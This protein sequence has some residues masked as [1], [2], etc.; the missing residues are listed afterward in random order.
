VSVPKSNDHHDGPLTAR[1][2]LTGDDNYHSVF[3]ALFQCTLLEK[4]NY[5]SAKKGSKAASSTRL[6]SCAKA[7]KVVVTHGAPRIKR[8]TA[9]ALIDHITQVLPGPDDDF[10]APLLQDYTRAFIALI[11]HPANIENF[12]VVNGELWFSCVDFCILAVS[13]FLETGDRGSASLSRASPA[14]GTAQTALSLA[15]SSGRSGSGS[16]HRLQGHL[17]GQ[18]GSVEAT[19]YMSCLNTLLTTAHAPVHERVSEVADLT[20]KVLEM[21][22]MKLGTLQQ[23]AFAC[24]NNVLAH[25]ST[26]DI[27]LGK[28]LARDLVPLISHWW[29]PQKRDA[30]TN[31]VRDEIL[32]TLYAIHLFLDSMAQESSDNSSLRELEDLLDVLWSEYSRREDRG[33]LLV[34]DLTFSGVQLPA[35][36]PRTGVFSLRPCNQAAEQNWALM[37]IVAIL[38]LL[39]TRHTK[40]IAAHVGEGQEQPRKRRRTVADGRGVT[41]NLTSLDPGMRLTALQVLPFIFQ[42]QQFFSEEVAECLDILTSLMSDKQ[43][44]V[45]TWAMLACCRYVTMILISR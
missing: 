21:R 12:A 36:H 40:R 9:R 32:K 27:S 11:D 23:V 26:D 29:P 33:R 34:D 18:I 5:F 35:D 42:H 1:R 38:E 4:Q 24:T 14:P 2:S 30:M 45:A 13:R 39:Y 31:T 41:K 15:F 6:E 44:L 25:V 16:A 28:R 8:K 20:L 19:H 7:L 22:Q 43:S 10:V 3:E 37:E 17:S